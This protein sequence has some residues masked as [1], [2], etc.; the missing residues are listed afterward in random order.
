[1]LHPRTTYAAYCRLL[2]DIEA[3]GMRQMQ[4]SRGKNLHEKLQTKFTRGY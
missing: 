2:G 1:V 3:G 4:K